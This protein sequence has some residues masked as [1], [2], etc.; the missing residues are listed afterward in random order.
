MTAHVLMQRQEGFEIRTH[1]DAPTA[2]VPHSGPN[3]FPD[4]ATLPGFKQC[5]EQY[6]AAVSQ[7]GRHV[8]T[9]LAEGLQLPP[10]FFT[11]NM[12]GP[13]SMSALK[14]LKYPAEKSNVAEGILGA[15]AHS[16]YGLLTFLITDSCPGLE[17]QLNGRWQRVTPRPK[18][19][20]Y[21]KRYCATISR[22]RVTVLLL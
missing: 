2:A 20:N 22:F 18:V 5:L 15:G 4:E 21:L 6:Y 13:S 10:T 12:F 1:F 11:D 3:V 19:R 7:L 14:L 9:L 17:V 8:A 16:D